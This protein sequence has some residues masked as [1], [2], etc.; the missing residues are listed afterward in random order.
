MVG[1]WCYKRFDIVDIKFNV[2]GLGLNT[3]ILQIF[4]SFQFYDGLT[5]IK[6]SLNQ[7]EIGFELNR[8]QTI[9]ASHRD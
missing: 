1:P 6:V 4:L 8:T 9:Q 5:S 2:V 7:L 3:K